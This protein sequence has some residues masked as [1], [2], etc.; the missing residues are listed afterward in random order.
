MSL[1]RRLSLIFKSKA[2]AI[3]DRAEDPRERTTSASSPISPAGSPS[4]ALGPLT[5][6][7]RGAVRVGVVCE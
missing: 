2:I 5:A 4:T 7:A 3:L 1:G 6:T